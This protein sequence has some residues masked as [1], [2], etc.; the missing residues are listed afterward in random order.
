MKEMIVLTAKGFIMGIANVIPGVSG[1]TLALILG[2]YEAF[3]GAISHLFSN[4]KQNLRILI[5]VGLGMVLS[6]ATM[7]HVIDF[8][9]RTYPLPT[10]TFFVGLVLGGVP[11]LY[12]KIKDGKAEKKELSSWVIF[13]AAFAL[14]MVMTFADQLFG[15]GLD[16]SFASMSVLDYGML[17]LVG[18]IASA[19]MVIPGVSGSLVL[20]LLG[21]YYPV[22]AVIKAI[23]QFQDLP[24]H[25]LVAIVFGLGI[26]IGIVFIAKVIEYLFD[27]FPIKTYYGVLGFVLASV[28]AIPISGLSA[29]TVMIDIWQIAAGLVMAVVGFVTAYYLGKA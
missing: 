4:L 18:I 5:P 28:I 10:T 14:V 6:I 26:L 22:I 11:M 8:C 16:V 13:A 7:S 12:E 27:H 21:Y 2:I 17:F 29:V 1:G 25:V 23:T 19:T 20:M 24:H 15:G 3:I 9:Y